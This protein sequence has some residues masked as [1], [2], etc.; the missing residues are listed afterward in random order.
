MRLSDGVIALRPIT[1]ADA[2]A[3]LAGEDEEL[4]RWLNG[5]PG[6]L[7][8]VVEHFER[9]VESWAAEGPCRTFAILD[10]TSGILVGT[11]DIHTEQPYLAAGQA[12]V[13]Y[14]IYPDWR[15]RGL[16]TRAVVLGCRYLSRTGLAEEAV[17]RVEP[18]N[19]A[20]V[21]VARRA[22]FSYSHSSNDGN[23]DLVDWYIQAV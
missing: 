15:G 21:A 9:C 5:G 1:V 11:L 17:I 7:Q 6:T 23:D 10:A 22:R 14:G 20:S 8:S 12:N 3:H 13:A 16:A 18:E 19:T 2:E 4:A